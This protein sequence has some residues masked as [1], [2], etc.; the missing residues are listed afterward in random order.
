QIRNRAGE[1]R[2][3]LMNIE[4]IFVDGI[5]CLFIS[6]R[7]IT[8]NKRIVKAIEVSDRRFQIMFENAL[9]GMALTDSLTNK[10]FV[11]NQKYLEIVGALEE[12]INSLDW[13]TITH[14]DD[15]DED[16]GHMEQLISGE[17][18]GYEMEKRY[19]R[20]DGSLCWV[21]LFVHDISFLEDREK[22]QHFVMLID[23]TAKKEAELE[24]AVSR[25]R[26]ANFTKASTDWYW[27]T[28][29]D[30]RFTYIS[31]IV[32]KSTGLSENQYI[33]KTQQETYGD[34]AWGQ[35]ALI[36]LYNRL[37]Q[38]K[39]FRDLVFYRINK[40]T[41]KKVWL[42]TSGQPFYDSA[43]MFAG[44]RG[45]TSDIT[46][47]LELEEKLKQSQKMEAV[48]Q[49]TGGIAH[50]FNNLLAVIQGNVELV[51]EALEEGRPVQSAQLRPVLNA[52]LRGAELTQSMLAFSRK[53]ELSPV[54][55]RLDLHVDKL[56]NM[57]QRTLGETIKIITD[58]E[59]NLWVCE[60]DPGQVENAL[61]NLCLNARD[62]MPSGGILSISV[63]NVEFGGDSVL[64][65][66]DFKA[67]KYVVLAVND[68][69]CGMDE[70]VLEHVMEPFYT[71]KE[72]G[73]GTGLGLSMVYGFA[74]QSKGHLTINSELSVGT[75]VKL[76][77][78]FAVEKSN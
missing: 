21:E 33:G 78:P 35:D 30:T 58:F 77:L 5:K 44:F 22:K 54:V 16:L 3:V 50:D 45:S 67:G 37:E 10:V 12:D 28:D 17:I 68:T 51:S 19:V 24:L 47:Q 52:T 41:G 27:E 64:L 76:Y 4:V 31:S 59:E 43:D 18:S 32:S 11:A 15:L 7:D 46:N 6:S 65:Q 62:A 20:P 9:I 70:N 29:K 36:S 14:P 34:D 40:K 25:D 13:R 26:F 38:K 74:R 55:L 69:G 60:A 48:G 2:D 66:P 57:L 63:Q 53:Q 73:K 39:G 1:Y 42:R 56:V 61:L 75:T 49:L 23:I 71:T 72:I 8:E